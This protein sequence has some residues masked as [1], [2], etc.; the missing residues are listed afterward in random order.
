MAEIII[1]WFSKAQVLKD[2][3][4]NLLMF[5]LFLLSLIILNYPV[6]QAELVKLDNVTHK[7]IKCLSTTDKG[8]LPLRTGREL[9]TRLDAVNPPLRVP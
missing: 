7:S 9:R 4:E 6:L 8:T 2:F 3:S 1:V 5:I